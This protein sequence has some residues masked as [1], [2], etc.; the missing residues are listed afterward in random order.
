MGKNALSVSSS[1]YGVS[2]FKV[3]NHCFSGTPL[4]CFSLK[5]THFNLVVVYSKSL[6]YGTTA[7]N[8]GDSS[9][10]TVGSKSTQFSAGGYMMRSLAVWK[11]ALSPQEVNSIYLAGKENAIKMQMQWNAIIR[12]TMRTLQNF[13]V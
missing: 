11:R 13:T 4:L 12:A 6:R 10:F 3:G 5:L 1:L 8:S 7:I 9:A 2:L